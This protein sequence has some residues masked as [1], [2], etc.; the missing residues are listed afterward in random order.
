MNKSGLI[1][2]STS[3]YRKALLERL[4]LPFTTARPEVDEERLSGESPGE[5]VLRLSKAKARAIAGPNAEALVIGSDQVAVCEGKI[6]G[7]PGNH[8]RAVEQLSQ[9]SGRRV[10]FLTGLCLIDGGTDTVQTDIVPFSVL[11]RHLSAEE[12]ESYLSREQPYN[13]AGSFKSEGLGIVLFERME[14]TDPT[15]LIGLPLIRLIDML[16]TAGVEVLAV[17][18]Q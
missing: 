2:A 11:F 7:K 4:R 9:S 18:N 13:S 12:I 10:E 6:L 14:G 15:A 16:K 17:N 5:L 1:L 8:Q 3:P